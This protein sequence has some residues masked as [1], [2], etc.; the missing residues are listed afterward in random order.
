MIKTVLSL[1]DEMA[2]A[3]AVSIVIAREHPEQAQINADRVAKVR[4]KLVATLEQIEER[5][6]SANL[7]TTCTPIP[8]IAS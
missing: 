1:A 6:K 2:A 5:L 3:H 4:T 7:P 8:S